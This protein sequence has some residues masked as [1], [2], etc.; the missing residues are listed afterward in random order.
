MTSLNSRRFLSLSGAR[1]ILVV[2]DANADLGAALTHFPREGHDHPLQALTWDSGGSGANVATA[3]GLF[4]GGVRLLARVGS[5]PAAEVALRAARAARVDLSF[6]QRDEAVATGLCFAAVSPGGE[7]TFFSHRGA[8]ACLALPEVDGL[9]DGVGWI[10]VAGHALLEG[11]QRET[12]LTLMAE[13]HRRGIPMSLDLC[14]PLL[15]AHPDTL[16]VDQ[17]SGRLTVLFANEPEL[18]AVTGEHHADLVEEGWLD[19]ALAVTTAAG[20]PLVAAKLGARG[21]LIAGLEGDRQTIPPFPVDARDT[22]GS[23]DAY[24]AAFLFALLTGA[25]ASTAGLLGNA[26]GAFVATRPG[27]ASA[28]PDRETLFAFA[29][30]TKPHDAPDAPDAPH[31]GSR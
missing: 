1:W 6:V 20:I 13:A 18:Q 22:T 15:A 27:A 24:V 28:L 11:V 2:G 17:G 31:R 8:N 14:L 3:L 19:R 12:T 26:A 21:S 4:G 30:H 7:R 29:D 16:T 10:H 25:P 23:G 5:D 9:L